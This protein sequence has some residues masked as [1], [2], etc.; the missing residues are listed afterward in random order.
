[1]VVLLHSEL[2]QHFSV[3]NDRNY[4]KQ[5]RKQPSATVGLPTECFASNTVL[6]Y[7]WSI[8]VQNEKADR[9]GTYLC[10]KKWSDAWMHTALKLFWVNINEK[11]ASGNHHRCQR[12]V[13]LSVTIHLVDSVMLRHWGISLI[14]STTSNQFVPSSIKFKYAWS[15]ALLAWYVNITSQSFPVFFKLLSPLL[16]PSV[17]H[18]YDKILM[19][20]M[21]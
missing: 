16:Q 11:A 14:L 15:F 5:V 19:H 2:Q 9:R 18:D 13:T 1:M 3:T 4:N 8:N 17:R 21:A 10:S 7:M 12:N 20:F 6:W